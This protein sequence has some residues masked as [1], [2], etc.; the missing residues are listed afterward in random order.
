MAANVGSTFLRIVLGQELTRL[1]ERAGFTGAAAAGKAGC[2]PST[3][4]DV[5]QG[6]TGFRRI[7]QLSRLLKAYGLD[8]DGQKLLMDWHRQAKGDD[9]WTSAVSV[10]PSGMNFFLAL[11]SG[12]RTMSVWVPGVVYGLLQTRDYAHALLLSAK[13]AHDTTDEFVERALEIRMTRQKRVTEE[14]MEL[15]CVMDEAA[16]TNRVGTPE[17]MRAQYK[18]IAELSERDNISIRIIPKAAP[19]YRVTSG[20]FTIMGFDPNQLPTPVVACTTVD[21]VTRV[22]SKAKQV[23]QFT[24]RFEVLAQGALPAYE[25]PKFLEQL[26]RE[27]T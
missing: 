24:R 19:T 21:S 14:G 17:I 11:E 23:K 10:L 2:S 16:L 27:V 20:D 5:E 6:K 13:V 3:I 26:S 22:A 8:E 9:W 7:E 25:T 12:T 1:R 15:T 18:H 4:S